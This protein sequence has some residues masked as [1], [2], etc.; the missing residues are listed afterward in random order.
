MIWFLIEKTQKK[1]DGAVGILTKGNINRTNYYKNAIIMSLVP[2]VNPK[3]S[4]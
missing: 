2:F 1:K 3:L 4:F